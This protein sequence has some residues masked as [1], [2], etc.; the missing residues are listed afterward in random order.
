MYHNHPNT[1]DEHGE[2]NGYGHPFLGQPSI[3]YAVPFTVG[4]GA[5]LEV[6]SSYS[7]YSD[8]DGATG[9]LHPPD[10]TIT[11]TAGT[12][13]GR[14]LDNVDSAGQ[15]RLKVDVVPAGMVICDAPHA[16]TGLKLTAHSNAIELAFASAASGPPSNRFDVRY[17]DKPITNDNFLD[18]TPSSNMPPPVG[19]QGS[20]VTTLIGGLRPQIQYFVAVRALA[21]C[22]AVSPVTTGTTTT[23]QATFVTLHGCFIATAAYGSPL[24]RELDVLRRLRDHRL[25]NNPF[26]Q[27]AVAAYYAFSPPLANAIASDERLRAAARR[28]IA[29][30]V[31]AARAGERLAP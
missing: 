11:D 31:D 2:L 13:A 19:A 20:T 24:A 25:L 12:G 28:L 27:L 16:P 15:W 9:T 10:F 1:N 4:T 8:W 5:D 30:L 29:P 7:G 3:V 18:A 17:S 26:G 23:T 14:L 21:M 22:G 6:T